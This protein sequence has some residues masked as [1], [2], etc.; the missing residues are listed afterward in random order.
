MLMLLLDQVIFK[1]SQK[2]LTHI[3]KS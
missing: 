2:L 1:P 3:K